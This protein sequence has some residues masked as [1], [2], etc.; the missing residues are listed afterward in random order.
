MLET[1]RLSA[2]HSTVVTPSL[3]TSET[4]FR[5]RARLLRGDRLVLSA[6]RASTG[7]KVSGVELV[8]VE[9]VGVVFGDVG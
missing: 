6:R 9:L 8:G 4:I 3:L 7:E 5:K 2:S 1:S